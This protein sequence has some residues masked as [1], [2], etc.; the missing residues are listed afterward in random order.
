MKNTRVWIAI[1]AQKDNMLETQFILIIALKCFLK[2]DN[3]VRNIRYF[4]I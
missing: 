2:R 4:L 1:P 3:C